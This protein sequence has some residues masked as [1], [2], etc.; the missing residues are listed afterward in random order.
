MFD[1]LYLLVQPVSEQRSVG[2][3]LVLFGKDNTTEADLRWFQQL[4]FLQD[5]P[6]LENQYPK[7]LPIGPRME[8]A[9][10]ADSRIVAEVFYGLI[11][12]D[13]DSVVNSPAAIGFKPRLAGG[14]GALLCMRN[15]LDF[16]WPPAS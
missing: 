3:L 9:V 11:D 15:L 2:N 8:R 1:A 12:Q 6:I 13:P 5:K 10:A 14:D 4:I 16:A 7:R